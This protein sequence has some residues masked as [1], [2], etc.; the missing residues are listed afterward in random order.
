MS[1]VLVPFKDSNDDEARRTRSQFLQTL[2]AKLLRRI[3]R[4]PNWDPQGEFST[5][6]PSGQ[7]PADALSDIATDANRL[8]IWQ[9]DD[10]G[11]NL[12]RV[13][14]AIASPRT[15]LQKLDYL[16][17]DIQDVQVLEI[18]I[19]ASQG[20]TFDEEANKSWHFH[21][22]RLSATALANLANRMLARGPARRQNERQLIA[23]IDRSVANGWIDQ[24]RLNPS[25]RSKL[26]AP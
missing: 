4:K 19:E 8:S 21:L 7:A 1:R 13:L 11:T 2:M 3:Q 5:Y 18:S 9:I 12:D 16:I 26:S 15:N 20:N 17:F 25:I 6:L 10:E 14:A 24:S 23:L 22:T